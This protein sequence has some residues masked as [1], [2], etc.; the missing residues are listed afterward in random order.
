M[1]LRGIGCDCRLRYVFSICPRFGSKELHM[2][3]PSPIVLAVTIFGEHEDEHYRVVF[4]KEEI[5][6]AGETRKAIAKAH[7]RRGQR[8]RDC[9]STQARKNEDTA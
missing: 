4:G 1:L 8:Q 5:T 2:P 7:P 3:L 9:L 6:E